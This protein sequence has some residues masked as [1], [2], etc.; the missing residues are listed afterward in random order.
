MRMYET[1]NK[2]TA[3]NLTLGFHV[4]EASV[5]D[6]MENPISPL[7]VDGNKISLTVKPFEIVTLRLKR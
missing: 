5:A 4:S 2:R 6:L 3:L 1:K 7:A